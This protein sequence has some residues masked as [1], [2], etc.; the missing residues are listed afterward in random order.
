MSLWPVGGFQSDSDDPYAS[1]QRMITD[2]I[3]ISADWLSLASHIYAP[4]A[5]SV[6]EALSCALSYEYVSPGDRRRVT[7]GSAFVPS[8]IH[9]G[10]VFPIPVPEVPD[11]LVAI[12]RD[13][14]TLIEHDP[15]RCR[16]A[17][18]VN[19]YESRSGSSGDEYLLLAL[20]SYVATSEMAWSVPARAAALI[21]ASELATRHP[22]R[23]PVDVADNCVTRLAEFSIRIVDSDVLTSAACLAAL[24]GLRMREAARLVILAPAVLRSPDAAVRDAVILL[25]MLSGEL[26]TDDA[27]ERRAA[28]WAAVL[29]DPGSDIR[30][31]ATIVPLLESD[32]TLLGAVRSH[33]LSA[34]HH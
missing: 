28:L 23:I 12:W 31:L 10:R 9:S 33:R 24:V 15:V 8:A 14:V 22:D 30:T 25:R 4:H 7:W 19:E 16:V 18:L 3:A 32:A 2:T 17:D 29:D 13:M 5:S 34:R 27:L 21:R 20:R 6:V 11:S 26:D 1:L